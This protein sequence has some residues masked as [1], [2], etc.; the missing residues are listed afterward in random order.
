MLAQPSEI[1]KSKRIA[2]FCYLW[3]RVVGGSLPRPVQI[4]AGERFVLFYYVGKPMKTQHLILHISP[5]GGAS[6]A[7]PTAGLVVCVESMAFDVRRH[8]RAK[9]T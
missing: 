8:V 5:D 2:N 7:C 4:F 6:V 3:A 9:G 1:K